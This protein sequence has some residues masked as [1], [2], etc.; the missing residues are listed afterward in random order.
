MQIFRKKLFEKR[1]CKK[2]EIDILRTDILLY[3]QSGDI[4]I[5]LVTLGL[6][7]S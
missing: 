7:I 3:D 5:G 4:Q 1:K 6:M 2:T